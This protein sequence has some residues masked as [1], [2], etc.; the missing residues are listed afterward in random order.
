MTPEDSLMIREKILKG[1]Y[2]SEEIEQMSYKIDKEDLNVFKELSSI[3]YVRNPL[4]FQKDLDNIGHEYSQNAHVDYFMV[5]LP[6]E[7]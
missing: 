1:V 4:Q 2:S 3:K 6:I 7:L 5:F